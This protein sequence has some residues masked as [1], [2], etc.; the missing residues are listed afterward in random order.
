MSTQDTEKTLKESEKNAKED[1]KK[2]QDND[3]EKVPEEEEAP[4]PEKKKKSKEIPVISLEDEHNTE[5]ELQKEQLKNQSLEEQQEAVKLSVQ[6]TSEQLIEERK[7]N[8]ELLKESKENA[9]QIGKLS[10]LAKVKM[11][12]LSKLM[13][14]GPKLQKAGKVRLEDAESLTNFCGTIFLQY[15]VLVKNNIGFEN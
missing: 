2:M 10:F 11:D 5:F 9:K 3:D 4:I 14:E 13:D 1:E 12:E 7:L 15:R 8:A 6:E